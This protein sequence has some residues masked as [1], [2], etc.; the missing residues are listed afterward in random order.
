MAA[1]PI[2]SLARHALAAEEAASSKHETIQTKR[3]RFAPKPTVI[4]DDARKEYKYLFDER[5][6]IM[7]EDGCLL[8]AE[9]R[10]EALYELGCVEFW[11]LMQDI[12]EQFSHLANEATELKQL[13]EAA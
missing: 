8:E 4:S 9:A 12:S 2:V 3:H 10:H 6:S 13:K 5:V 1:N 7:V 11:D